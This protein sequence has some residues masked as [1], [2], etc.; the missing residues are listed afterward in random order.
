MIWN[1]LLN[2]NED[3]TPKVP[4]ENLPVE[5]DLDPTQT[6]KYKSKRDAKL[7]QYQFGLG[8]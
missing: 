1:Y 8:M 2:M 3:D 7:R 4:I 5:L 6:D